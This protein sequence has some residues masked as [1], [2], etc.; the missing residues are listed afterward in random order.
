M[1]RDQAIIFV[2]KGL[3]ETIGGSIEFTEETDLLKDGFLD[4]LDFVRF[5]FNLDKIS[6]TKLPIVDVAGQ[7]LARI[8]TL[9]DFMIEHS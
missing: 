6:S 7:G 1:D 4:S 9:V 5:I 3:I 2:D 8:G